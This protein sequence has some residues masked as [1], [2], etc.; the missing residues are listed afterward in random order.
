LKIKFIKC[1]DQEV[2]AVMAVLQRAFGWCE[3]AGYRYCE[4]V[5]GAIHS[6]AYAK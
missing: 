6:T 3:K 4:F 2:V 5:L 1:N